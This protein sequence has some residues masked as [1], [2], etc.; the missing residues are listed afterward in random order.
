M[1][2]AI[3]ARRLRIRGETGARTLSLLPFASLDPVRTVGYRRSP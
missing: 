2:S 3:R 1:A